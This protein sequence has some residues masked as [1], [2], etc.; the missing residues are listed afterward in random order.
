MRVN[1]DFQPFIHEDSKATIETAG[2]LGESFVDIDSKDAKGAIVKDGTELPP[3]NAPGIQDV[4]KTSQTSL[5]NIDVLVKRA[6]CHPGR[7]PERQRL[8]GKVYL[9]SRHDQQDQCA[10]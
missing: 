3:G 4:V 8:A 6:D 1:K 5:Q 7:D 2:V 10:S 9:R